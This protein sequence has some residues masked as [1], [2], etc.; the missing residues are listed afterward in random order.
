MNS[1]CPVTRT[2][3]DHRS[4]TH[5]THTVARELWMPVSLQLDISFCLRLLTVM[6][7]K[8]A[9]DRLSDGLASQY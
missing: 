9:Q 2:L 7:P 5:M 3:I 6:A 8:T 4:W 1:G